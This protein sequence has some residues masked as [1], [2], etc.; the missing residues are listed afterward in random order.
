M[1]WMKL[2]IVKHFVQ[3]INYRWDI[4]YE[5]MQRRNEE[6]C[7]TISFHKKVLAYKDKGSYAHDGSKV[8]CISR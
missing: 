8:K 5:E 6:G 1:L 2:L 4:W 3:K 7:T